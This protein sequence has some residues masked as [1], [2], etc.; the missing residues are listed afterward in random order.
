MKLKATRVHLGLAG[1]WILMIIPRLTLLKKS[2]LFVIMMSLYANIEAS[3]AAYQ[4]AKT[5][6]KKKR[7][8]PRSVDLSHRG[9]RIMIRRTRR[10]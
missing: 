7:P 4:A 8:R 2:L 3:L 9:D 1:F 10:H 6:K 5:K